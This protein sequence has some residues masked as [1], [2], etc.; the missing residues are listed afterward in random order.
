MWDQNTSRADK[1]GLPLKINSDKLFRGQHIQIKP[2][3]ITANKFGTMVLNTEVDA[4]ANRK[5]VLEDN[6]QK[7]KSLM[8][9]QF[10]KPLKRKRKQS[11]GWSEAFTKLDVLNN[12]KII[13]Y[14]IFNIEDQ[15]YLPLFL[16]Q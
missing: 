3:A 11:K 13:K 10:T 8:L 1:S 5:S 15:K 7:A 16:H 6:I 9:G 12:I 14:I 4:Y 2:T